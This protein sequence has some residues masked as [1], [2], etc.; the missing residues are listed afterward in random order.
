MSA[1]EFDLVSRELCPDGACI[2]LIGPDGRCKECG[3]PG[4]TATQHPR[5]RGM[6]TRD[7]AQSDDGDGPEQASSSGER[8]V[9]SF[10]HEDRELCSD[11]GCIGVIGSDGRCKECGLASLEASAEPRSSASRGEQDVA[12]KRSA[13]IAK[14][15]LAA[16]PTGFAEREL[17]P[18]GACIGVIGPSGR[19]RECGRASPNASLDPRSRGLRR[20]EDVA[21]ELEANIA[22][23]DLAAAPD[24]FEE[25]ELCPNDACVGIIGQDGR[26]K[27]CGATREE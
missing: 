21:E 9:E 27:E 25:R 4:K 7:E 11:G 23:S 15:D 1:H 20:E 2:G 3:L 16:A 24:D 18:D 8:P 12:E 10:A 17:C 14:S 5:N 22:K 19:C 6:V 13:G 26:C